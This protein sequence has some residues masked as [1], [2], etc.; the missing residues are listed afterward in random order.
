LNLAKGESVARSKSSLY[1][2]WKE[3]DTLLGKSLERER[4]I[5]ELAVERPD[6]ERLTAPARAATQEG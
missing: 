3:V 2:E 5:V 6:Y 4:A 1:A